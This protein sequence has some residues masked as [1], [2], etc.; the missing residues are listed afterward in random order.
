MEAANNQGNTPLP[1]AAPVSG[2]GEAGPLKLQF[3]VTLPRELG[4]ELKAWR[5]LFE[6]FTDVMERWLESSLAHPGLPAPPVMP[7]LPAV[8]RTPPPPAPLSPAPAARTVETPLP[9]VETPLP[10]LLPPSPPAIPAARRGEARS[11]SE[12]NGGPRVAVPEFI[13]PDDMPPLLVEDSRPLQAAMPTQDAPAERAAARQLSEVRPL[14]SESESVEKEATED[15][16]AAEEVLTQ[17][18]QGER[19][20]LAGQKESA[21]DCYQKALA[22]DAAC[23]QAYLGRASIYIQQGRLN[24]ALLDCNSALRQ[25]PDRA[26]LYVLRG[27][28]YERLGKLKRAL[29]EAEDAVRFD[30][31]LPSAY[32]LRG[33]VRF[34]KGMTGE[35]LADVRQAIRLRPG[36]A[37][38][39][40][41]LARLLAHTGQYEQAA[42]IYAKVLELAPNFHE[43]RFSRGAALRLAGETAEAQAELTE[44]LRRRPRSADAHYQRGLCRLAQCNYAQAMTDFD[45]AI[46]LNP[47]DEAVRQAKEKTL[48]QWEGTAK[49]G[50]S[51]SGS[52]A[53]V[54]LTATA[55]DKPAAEPTHSTPVLS[56]PLPPKTSRAKT[57]P[58]R[59]RPPRWSDDANP[60]RWSRPI[61]WA[62]SLVLVAVLGY[63][64][65][66][67]VWAYVKLR[68]IPQEDNIPVAEAK[69]TAAELFEHFQTNAQSAQSEFGQK[70]IEVQGIVEEVKQARS[71]ENDTVQIVLVGN[72][73]GGLIVC[74]LAPTKS[75]NQ[76]VRLSRVDRFGAVKLIGKCAGQAD[77][78]V[79]LDE[80]RLIEVRTR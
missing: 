79:N 71:G 3:E 59:S 17:L 69:V 32:M 76:G 68:S 26:V 58:R 7:L 16:A 80:V 61:K 9:T 24:E 37:K 55:A 21:L 63:L 18:R 49:Q 72:R 43:A 38:F 5:R 11:E 46:A 52:A 45:K 40:A 78:A 4:G 67:M 41:E 2:D 12:R 60:N 44:Y 1:S 19:H 15:S 77:K 42:R 39:H 33:N 10:L 66:P 56:K 50:R 6:R 47:D 14:P 28:V 20:R 73:F 23:M 74:T 29:D 35:A 30:P 22:L 51:Q 57:K 34:K 13:L 48:E 25:Q 62:G 75:L 8:V 64:F 31:R 53:T 54:A 70:F 36:D 27:L 65:V